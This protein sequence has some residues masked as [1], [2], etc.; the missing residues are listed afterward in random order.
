M[1]FT[2]IST[3]VT[4]ICCVNTTLAISST[5]TSCMPSLGNPSDGFQANFYKYLYPEYAGE[6]SDEY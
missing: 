4:L 1:T 6:S 5:G 3:I 2:I